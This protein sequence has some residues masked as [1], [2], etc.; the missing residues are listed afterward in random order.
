MKSLLG[1]FWEEE[2]SGVV[3]ATPDGMEVRRT[4]APRRLLL[5][6]AKRKPAHHLGVLAAQAAQGVR[7]ICWRETVQETE[8][9]NGS[10]GCE[11]LALKRTV[12]KSLT[13]LIIGDLS[14]D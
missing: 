14:P 5:Q 9:R 8:S 4:V 12:T 6:V 11:K 7:G 3:N 1:Y 10:F 2:E 13:T